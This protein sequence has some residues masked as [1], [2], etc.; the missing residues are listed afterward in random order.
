MRAVSDDGQP[1]HEDCPSLLMTISNE[2]V[3][4]TK[5]FSGKGTTKCRSYLLDDPPLVGM[6][7]GL[8]TAEKTMLGFGQADRVRDFRQHF[9]NEMGDRLIGRIEE[10]TGRKVLTYQSQIMF[11]PDVVVELFV[12]EDRLP[13]HGIE[14]TAEAQLENEPAGEVTTGEEPSASGQS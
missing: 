3:M 10:L 9:E 4:F 13:E 1:V 7:G 12:F 2:L 8:T 6:R 14:A 5:K 11:D